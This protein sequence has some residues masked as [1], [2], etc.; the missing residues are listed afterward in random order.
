MSMSRFFVLISLIGLSFHNRVIKLS[1]FKDDNSYLPVRKGSV[2]TVEVEGNPKRGRIWK[3][4][5]PEKL[6]INN[7]ISPVNLDEARSG[8]FYS[9]KG[10]DSSVFSNGFYHFKFQATNT[11]TGHETISFAFHDENGLQKVI[12]KSINIHVVEGPKRDL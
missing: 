7:I 10:E 3:V 9:N 4:D 12:K 11:S 1:D 5:E 2:F 8:V 6:T